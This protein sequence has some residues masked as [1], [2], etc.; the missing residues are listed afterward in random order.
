[1]SKRGDPAA[2]EA[3]HAQRCRTPPSDGTSAALRADPET[4]RWLKARSSDA[5]PR[6]R[7]RLDDND[8]TKCKACLL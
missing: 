1:M 6:T 4:G 8:E 2:R 3:A 5:R 7:P